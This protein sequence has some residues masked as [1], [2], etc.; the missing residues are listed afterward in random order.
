M[1]PPAPA[2][3]AW[4]GSSQS[5]L[6]W[7]LGPQLLSTCDRGETGCALAARAGQPAPRPARGTAQPA[8]PVPTLPTGNWTP[9]WTATRTEDAA[10]GKDVHSKAGRC[11]ALS[12]MSPEFSGEKKEEAGV[13]APGCNGGARATCQ[14]RGANASASEAPRARSCPQCVCASHPHRQPPPAGGAGTRPLLEATPQEPQSRRPRT[15]RQQTARACPAW[16]LTRHE[17]TRGK[18]ERGQGPSQRLRGN[19]SD[20]GL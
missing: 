8:R 7:L 2:S 13:N 10:K 18:G 4:P 20:R 14:G 12:W 1:V 11:F 6:R 17:G 5:V 19:R 16:E 9:D 3:Q 15:S